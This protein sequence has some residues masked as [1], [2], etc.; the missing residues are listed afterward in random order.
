M[1]GAVFH[2]ATFNNCD[3][4]G[5]EIEATDFSSATFVNTDLRQAKV[6]SFNLKGANLENAFRGFLEYAIQSIKRDGPNSV[7]SLEVLSIYQLFQKATVDDTTNVSEA[8]REAILMMRRGTET[9]PI[10]L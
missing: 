10:P 5:A 8:V 2:S 6:V 4:K 1:K 9:L 7:N 3:L